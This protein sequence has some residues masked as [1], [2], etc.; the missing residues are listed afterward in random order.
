M[1]GPNWYSV[2]RFADEQWE[3]AQAGYWTSV[4]THWGDP[5]KLDRARSDLTVKRATYRDTVL[6]AFWAYVAPLKPGNCVPTAVAELLAEEWDE[7]TKAPPM[8]ADFL[9][10][11]QGPARCVCRGDRGEAQAAQGQAVTAL[12]DDCHAPLAD[13]VLGCPQLR[14]RR[15]GDGVVRIEPSGPCRCGATTTRRLHDAWRCVACVP[16]YQPA[17]GLFGAGHPVARRA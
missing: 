10:R 8:T 12:C 6:R 1:D 15:T 14:V 13:H 11:E 7:P 16:V 5:V 17:A 3:A 4:N 2:T 9:D